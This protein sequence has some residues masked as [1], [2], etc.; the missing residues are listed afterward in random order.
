MLCVS[1]IRWWCITY[2][3]DLIEDVD[4]NLFGRWLGEDSPNQLAMPLYDTETPQSTQ[5]GRGIARV[6]N[7]PNQTKAQRADPCAFTASGLAVPRRRLIHP[8][9]CLL[10]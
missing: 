6:S 8:R 10:A 9:A 1:V 7:K 2:G 5:G 3:A 4:G